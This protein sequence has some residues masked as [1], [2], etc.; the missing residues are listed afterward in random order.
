MYVV[1][2]VTTN[3]EYPSD[4]DAQVAAALLAEGG[5]LGVGDNVLL[6]KFIASLD[7]IGGITDVEVFIQSGGFPVPPAGNTNIS[8]NF[9]QIA[10]F[11]SARINII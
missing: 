3:S 2:D 5:L 7:A 4:G 8:I 6:W 11:D 10:R 9:R 1:C